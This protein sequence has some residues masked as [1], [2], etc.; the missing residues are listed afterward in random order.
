MNES[1]EPQDG[2]DIESAFN[3]AVDELEAGV[4]NGYVKLP[5]KSICKSKFVF[6]CP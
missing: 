2:A 3:F 4:N 6:V 5:G 1:T